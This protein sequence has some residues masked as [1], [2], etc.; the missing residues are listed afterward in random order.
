MSISEL[1]EWTLLQSV[2]GIEQVLLRHLMIFGRTVLS[3][4]VDHLQM[5][6]EMLQHAIAQIDT[7]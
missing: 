5:E 7:L 2:L 6:L 3:S 4:E 1:S